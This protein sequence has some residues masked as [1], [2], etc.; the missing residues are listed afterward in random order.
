MSTPSAGHRQ[1]QGFPHSPDW[2]GELGLGGA[3]CARACTPAKGRSL[4]FALSS[5]GAAVTVA[6]LGS[7]AGHSGAHLDALAVVDKERGT[8]SELHRAG[9]PGRQWS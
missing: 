1:A 2:G 7:R 8:A 9:H 3:G 5:D 6:V 4:L